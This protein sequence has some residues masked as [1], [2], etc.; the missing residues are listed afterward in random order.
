MFVIPI[1]P[2][3]RSRFDLTPSIRKPHKPVQDISGY[4]LFS[5]GEAGAMHVMAHRMLDQKRI[6]PGRTLLGAW[7]DRRSGSGSKWIHLQW[8]MAVFDLSSGHWHTAYARFR[9]HI[10]PAATE[11]FDALT[12]APALLWRLS[13]ASDNSVRLPWEPVRFRALEAMHRPCSPF[14]KIHNLLAL[15][16]AGDVRNLEKSIQNRT[17]HTRSGVESLVCRIA[18][19]LRSYVGGDYR[20]AAANFK[21]VTPH[22][23]EWGGSRAQNDLFRHLQNS[24]SHKSG[25]GHSLAPELHVA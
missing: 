9:K 13:L 12:D 20:A 17:P 18:V 19:A 8:H 5:E 16:G 3:Q 14:V 11:S 22:V 24:A 7:L 23:A 21:Q 2:N 1:L 4:P 6:E 25:S 15:A 10:L